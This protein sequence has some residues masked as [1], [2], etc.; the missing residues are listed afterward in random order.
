M[1]SFGLV[2]KQFSTWH[3][4]ILLVVLTSDFVVVVVVMNAKWFI[5]TFAFCS[6]CSGAFR[7][8]STTVLGFIDCEID[9]FSVVCD[10]SLWILK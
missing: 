4:S 7:A 9:E 8:Y 1:N 3:I 2:L 10:S 6:K 5:I